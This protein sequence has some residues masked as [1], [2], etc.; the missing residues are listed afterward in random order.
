MLSSNNDLRSVN[1][2]GKSIKGTGIWKLFGIFICPITLICFYILSWTDPAFNNLSYAPFLTVGDFFAFMIFS[3]LLII[4]R[5]MM[6]VRGFTTS[7][8]TGIKEY[9]QFSLIYLISYIIIILMF[10]FLI[11]ELADI[12]LPSTSGSTTFSIT[13]F[14]ATIILFY[15][16]ASFYVVAPIIGL[17]IGYGLRIISWFFLRSGAKKT[18]DYGKVRK[19]SSRCILMIVSSA[20]LL[21]FSI[22]VFIITYS[23]QAINWLELAPRNFLISIAVTYVSF[24]IL[25]IYSFISLGTRLK[26][27]WKSLNKHQKM[28]EPK[29]TED[30][31]QSTQQSGNNNSLSYGNSTQQSQSTQQSELKTPDGSIICSKC[32][33]PNSKADKICKS[34]GKPL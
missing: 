31:N 34:C 14:L 27:G 23:N 12:L 22:L 19:A 1:K 5:I 28:E 3:I 32:G 9:K 20:I 25:E 18:A 21:I 29:L 15:T 6:I 33:S 30:L 7:W 24:F 26:S 8:A 17:F 13:Y 2:L 16:H 10:G 11:S 4:Y